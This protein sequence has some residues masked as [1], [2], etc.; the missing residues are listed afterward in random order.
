M[1]RYSIDGMRVKLKEVTN[2]FAASVILFGAG[3]ALAA[4]LSESPKD[5]QIRLALNNLEAVHRGGH[6]TYS[7]FLNQTNFF[8]IVA[9][10]IVAAIIVVGAIS[11]VFNAERAIVWEFRYM[12][13]KR[14]IA[15][16]NLYR[17]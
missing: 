3:L 2:H 11:T 14:R 16:A 4:A 5:S 17:Y 6:G 13:K 9:L 12:A 8:V 10:A 7:Q 15:R 1:V